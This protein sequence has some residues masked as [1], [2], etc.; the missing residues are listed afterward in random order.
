MFKKEFDIIFNY[1]KDKVEDIEILLTSDN[2]FSSRFHD[3]HIES[4]QSS[5]SRGIGIRIVHNGKMGYAYTENFSEEMLK[6]VVVQAKENALYSEEDLIDIGN[7]P[8]KKNNLVLYNN[9]LNSVTNENVVQVM[10]DLEKYAYKADKRVLNIPYLQFAKGKSFT[11]IVNNKGL[12]KEEKHNFATCNIGVLVGE[13]NERK[14]SMDYII[15]RNFSQINPQKLANN[16][17]SKALDLLNGN[18]AETGS[19][20]I[21][22]QNETM[23]NLIATFSMIFSGRAVLDGKSLLRDKVGEMIGSEKLNIVDNALHS[24]GFASSS[25][26]SEGFPSQ[27]TQLVHKGKLLSYLHNTQTAKMMNTTSTGNASRS[28]KSKLDVAPT[29]LI[30]ESGESSL[31][32][33]YNA[34]PEVIEIVSLQGLHSGTNTIS[35]DFSLSAEGFLYKNGV[36]QYA[37]KQF[38]VSGNI[39]DLFHHIMMIG[40]D[41]KFNYMSVGSPSVL[42]K[43]LAVSG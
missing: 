12:D 31:S 11:K 30:L 37:L 23:A 40:D 29:N 25:F 15:T 32:E 9:E 20:P 43:E 7:Y 27:K 10:E 28:Y 21:V 17:V 26:D 33:M 4:L 36:K 8:D 18:A 3:K 41:F 19:Y 22:I 13:G 16:A 34:F 6:K 24:Q 39:L 2:E 14:M 42:I 5:E 35:G 1:A 38:T